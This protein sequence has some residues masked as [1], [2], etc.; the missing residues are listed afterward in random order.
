M[1]VWEPVT[2]AAQFFSFAKAAPLFCVYVTAP[3]CFRCRQVAEKVAG[4]PAH[5]AGVRFYSVNLEECE[6]LGELLAINILPT[7]VLL[8]GGA[9]VARLEGAPQ[10]RPARR[11]AQAIRQHLLGEA[12]AGS[13]GGAEELEGDVGASQ[14]VGERSRRSLRQ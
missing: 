9:E 5:Y 12:P 11:L 14:D 10:Q 8:R 3:W 13:A 4:F 1:Q 7:F 6:E 2:S